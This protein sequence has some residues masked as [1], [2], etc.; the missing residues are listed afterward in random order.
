VGEDFFL[1]RN[2]QKVRCRRQCARHFYT[3]LRIFAFVQDFHCHTDWREHRLGAD[4]HSIP[5]RAALLLH[6]GSDQLHLAAHSGYFSHRH[7]LARLHRTGSCDL[8]E[9][10]ARPNVAKLDL[11]A[12]VVKS[13][14]TQKIPRVCCSHSPGSAADR[15]DGT[16]NF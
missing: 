7:T 5:G 6:P 13:F 1:W 2:C 11:R 9:V 8:E 14:K 16:T 10:S 3:S 12:A 4:Y 15:D